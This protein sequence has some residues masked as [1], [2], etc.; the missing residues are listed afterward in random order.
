MFRCSVA[1][2]RILKDFLPGTSWN[3]HC[4]EFVSIVELE[5]EKLLI[6]PVVRVPPWIFSRQL[7]RGPRHRRA[8]DKYRSQRSEF[9]RA[10][11]MDRYQVLVFRLLVFRVPCCAAWGDLQAWVAIT[12]LLKKHWNVSSCLSP[13]ALEERLCDIARTSRGSRNRNSR[14]S[15]TTDWLA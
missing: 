9:C 14:S 7:V 6:S 10:K 5:D 4:L 15:K 12:S 2:L 8:R 11:M 13:Q 3:F 1:A